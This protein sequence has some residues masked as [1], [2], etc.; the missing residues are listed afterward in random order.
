[1]D[2]RG[3]ELVGAELNGDRPRPGAWQDG[4]IPLTG[5]ARGQHADRRRAGWP[6][7][8]TARA[9]TATSTRTTSRPTCTPCRSSTPG[10]A[11]SPAST[12][13]T[14]RP[15]TSCESGAPEDWT[16]L[17]NGPSRPVEPG[18]W[19]ITPTGPL[20]SYLVTL[21]AGPYVSVVDEHA[22]IRLGLAR[23][24]QPAPPSWRRRPTTC[25]RS[26][27]RPW[28]TTPSCSACRTRSGS[29]T[30]RSCPT[31]TPERW[32]TPAASR[33]ATRFLYRGRATGRTGAERAGVVAH[34]LAHM[35]FGDLVTMR[36]WDDLWLNES[37]AEYLAHRCCA[38]V[39][40]VPAVDRVRGRCARTGA[41]I[42]DQS[43]TTHPVAGNDAAD[44]ETALQQ[45]DGISYAKGAAVLKQLAAYLGEDGVPRRPA[46]ATSDGYAWGN[47]T[48]ADLL[49]CLDRRRRGRISE[50][51]AAGLAADRRHGHAST[52]LAEPDRPAS[53]HP[54]APAAGPQPAARAR[55]GQRGR[56]TGRSPRWPTSP[57]PTIRCR[58]RRPPTPCCSSR[59]APTR[60]GP[61]SGSARTAGPGWL[62]C[63]RRSP[64]SRCW[65]WLYNAIRDAVRD[66]ELD[67]AA[68]LDLHPGGGAR[69]VGR[70]DGRGR[71]SGL[72]PTSWPVRT[73]RWPSARRGW[74]GSR[75]VAEPLLDAA[76]SRV[77]PAAG[78]L[79]PAGAQH[80][81]R[82]SA[83]G[84]G[85]GRATADGHRLDP[86][87]LWLVVRAAG[88]ARPRPRPDR[89][90]PG[91]GPECRGPDPRR[92]GPGD[93]GP[94]GGQGQRP[95]T[96]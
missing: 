40:G 1:M 12:S 76:P 50:P 61:R 62:G 37:F 24:G 46:V 47:A 72:P 96:G 59:T 45:F 64:T 8:A 57:W 69:L 75:D 23:P 58:D 68:A 94:A 84:L 55:R 36:W 65:W 92:P 34:E 71:C 49:A 4:R 14:S 87:L 21:V 93:P 88:R 41:P 18:R 13:P 42:A 78:R 70:D 33:C 6:T 80:R 56:R 32:R 16:V 19:V 25:S 74:P 9:C 22:G 53:C 67:P 63:C 66:A 86:E 7:A 52:C 95:G 39:D 60:P 35:W 31:S 27:G 89:G 44:A 38:A 3:R 17:G 43:P 20:P 54:A 82:R 29:T 90:G 30:R 26:P 10:R 79:P 11:G 15:R 5:L 81:R 73:P 28:T 48:F 91:S 51:W 2:F 85:G 77:G 83:A